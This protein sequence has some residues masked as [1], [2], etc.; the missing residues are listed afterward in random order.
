[1]SRSLW[2]RCVNLTEEEHE[3]VQLG[4]GDQAGRAVGNKKLG[5]EVYANT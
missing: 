4:T 3:L 5:Y 2:E 1:M